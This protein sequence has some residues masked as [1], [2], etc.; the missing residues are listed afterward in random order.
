M[1]TRGCPAARSRR[2]GMRHL[3]RNRVNVRSFAR[4]GKT[5]SPPIRWSRRVNGRSDGH[6]WLSDEARRDADRSGTNDSACGFGFCNG[7]LYGPAVDVAFVVLILK[8]LHENQT[9]AGVKPAVTKATA[10]AMATSNTYGSTR[11]VMRPLQ[12]Q[13]QS[14]NDRLRHNN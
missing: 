11:S 8:T 6:E 1:A 5:A 3:P 10:K 12:K 14:A 2:G 9:L 13:S 7:A 4:A